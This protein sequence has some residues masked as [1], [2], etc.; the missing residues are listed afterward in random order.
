MI[1]DRYIL[2]RADDVL[3]LT[4][5]TIRPEE[6]CRSA[7]LS[8]DMRCVECVGFTWDM[9]ASILVNFDNECEG[10]AKKDGSRVRVYREAWRM[11]VNLWETV[12]AKVSALEEGRAARLAAIAGDEGA[13]AVALME[14]AEEWEKLRSRFERASVMFERLPKTEEWGEQ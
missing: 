5:G 7:Y 10:P 6:S 2:H 1:P 3:T 9:P 13:R 14:E 8:K 12:V 11:T 4:L